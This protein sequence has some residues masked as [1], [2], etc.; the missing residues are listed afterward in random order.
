MSRKRLLKYKFSGT[1][2]DLAD[3]TERCS[4]TVD[5]GTLGASVIDDA[6]NSA[7]DALNSGRS[8]N[9]HKIVNRIILFP[10]L[11]KDDRW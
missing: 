4:R 11:Q 2:F 1:K 3:V 6:L 9:G 5:L 8:T 7:I 10:V